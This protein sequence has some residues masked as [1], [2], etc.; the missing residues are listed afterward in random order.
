VKLGSLSSS[1]SNSEKAVALKN[2]SPNNK[3]NIFFGKIVQEVIKVVE[4][5]Q[6]MGETA[7]HLK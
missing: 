5:E 1:N 7:E 4:R 2:K 3:I 6:N